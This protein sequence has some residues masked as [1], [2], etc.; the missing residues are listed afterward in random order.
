MAIPATSQISDATAF[1]IHSLFSFSSE[2]EYEED[3]NLR[4][5]SGTVSDKC[6][7]VVNGSV[8]C[9]AVKLLFKLAASMTGTEDLD[10]SF[11]LLHNM[12]GI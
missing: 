12:K 2:R 6:V 5:V 9:E 11:I 4:S 10:V 7:F 1:P 8:F 3:I